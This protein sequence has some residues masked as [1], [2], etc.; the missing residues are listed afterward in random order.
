M[1]MGWLRGW[2]FEKGFVRKKIIEIFCV[3]FLWGM[4]NIIIF[5]CEYDRYNM[6]NKMYKISI[7]YLELKVFIVLG[8]IIRFILIV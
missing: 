6:L 2:G 5:E 8:D 1:F 3:L 7:F 4:F